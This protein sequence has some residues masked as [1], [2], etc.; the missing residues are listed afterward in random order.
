[1]PTAAQHEV[2]GSS[3]LEFYVGVAPTGIPTIIINMTAMVHRHEYDMLRIMRN[4]QS[5]ART[6]LLAATKMSVEVLFF[7]YVA[8]QRYVI[9]ARRMPPTPDA[10]IRV[11]VLSTLK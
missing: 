11:I 3:H 2:A 8:L 9:S 1:M 10:F 7:F 4:L 6:R 5:P